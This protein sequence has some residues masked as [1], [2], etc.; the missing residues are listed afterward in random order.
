[1]SSWS[2]LP[3]SSTSSTRGSFSKSLFIAFLYVTPA[4]CRGVSSVTLRYEFFDSRETPSTY[5]AP[6]GNFPLW[7]CLS[8]L[9]QFCTL[10]CFVCDSSSWVVLLAR[11]SEV[12][13][14]NTERRVSDDAGGQTIRL[15]D[16]PKP[17]AWKAKQSKH[18]STAH[19]LERFRKLRHTFE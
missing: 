9:V 18:P 6:Y 19:S 17:P 13:Q 2:W 10:S 16:F 1:M 4:S 3:T 8:H 14:F 12:Q 15:Q 11:G 5:I 7:L